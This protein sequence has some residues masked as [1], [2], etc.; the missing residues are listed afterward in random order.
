M[1]RTLKRGSQTE[2][3]ASHRL[4]ESEELG[5]LKEQK[6]TLWLEGSTCKNT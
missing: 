4:W 2:R 5:L 1:L 3:K 6:E